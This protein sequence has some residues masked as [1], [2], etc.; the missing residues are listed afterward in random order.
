MRQAVI[1]VEGLEA[2]YGGAPVLHQLCFEVSKHSWAVLLGPN[3]SGKSTLL[4]SLIGLLAPYAGTARIDGLHSYDDRLEVRRITGYL[5]EELYLYNELRVLDHLHFAGGM[6]DIPRPDL[7]ARIAELAD[8]FGIADIMQCRVSECSHGMKRKLGICMAL[9]HRPRVL[10]FD[11]PFSGLDPLMAATTR[12]I[13]KEL[14]RDAGTSILMATHNLTMVHDYCDKLM[15]LDS[16]RLL[17]DTT[18]A[19]IAKEYPGMSLEEVFVTLV[20]GAQDSEGTPAM[21]A[22]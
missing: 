1:L 15:I 18:P 14:C 8:C 22:T 20:R 7:D 12:A 10:I 19:A 2:G 11:D 6:H 13:L 9:L 5:P 17:A 4:K 3:G 21:D 16:G